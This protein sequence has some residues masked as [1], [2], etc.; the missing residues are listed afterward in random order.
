M[1]L[2][3]GITTAPIMAAVHIFVYH[4]PG[5]LPVDARTLMMEDVWI[6]TYCERGWGEIPNELC[7]LTSGSQPPPNGGRIRCLQLESTSLPNYVEYF[8]GPYRHY[9]LL[10]IL[11]RISKYEKS[12]LHLR[13]II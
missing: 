5:D 13:L 9:A 10:L 11:Y 8:Q 7:E 4:G 1:L 2:L 12:F 6:G 3:Q